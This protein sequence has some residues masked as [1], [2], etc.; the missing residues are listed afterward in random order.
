MVSTGYFMVDL[1]I[2]LNQMLSFTETLISYLPRESVVVPFP[3]VLITATASRGLLA[4]ISKTLPLI[5]T[6]WAFAF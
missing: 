6:F 4:D 2:I 1:P 3:E 5:V